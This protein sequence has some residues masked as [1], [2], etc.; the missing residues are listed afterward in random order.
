[1]LIASLMSMPSLASAHPGRVLEFATAPLK[2][3]QS[4]VPART[5][6]SGPTADGKYCCDDEDWRDEAD[7][8]CVDYDANSWC[9]EYANW[10]DQVTKAATACC[11]CGGGTTYTD[12]RTTCLHHSWWVKGDKGDKGDTG[13][14]VTGPKGDKV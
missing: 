1:M 8:N 6:Y 3:K 11:G 13:E 14:S 9:P 7:Y 2:G 10:G 4:G 5:S 12:G